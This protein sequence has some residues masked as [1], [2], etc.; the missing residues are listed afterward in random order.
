MSNL[1]IYVCTGAVRTSWIC[2]TYKIKINEL[3]SYNQIKFDS[4]EVKE[5]HKEFLEAGD[6]NPIYLASKKYKSIAEYLRA[7]TKSNE[8]ILPGLAIRLPEQSNGGVK[9]ENDF[10]FSQVNNITNSSDRSLNK[11]YLLFDEHSNGIIGQS[12]DSYFVRIENNKKGE[13][14]EHTR[15]PLPVTPQEFSDSNQARWNSVSMMGRSVDYQ[16]YTG[17]SR[18]VSF[19][20]Q[21]HEEVT[22]TTRGDYNNIHE[23]VAL[24]ESCCYP[25][26]GGDSTQYAG[27]PEVIFKIASQFYIKGILESCSATWTPPFIDGRYVNC[28]LSVSVKETTGPYSATEIADS[29]SSGLTHSAVDNKPA[30][31]RG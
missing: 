21:L 20:L 17:S 6:N 15:V 26:Y 1:Q 30:G 22:G 11:R 25:F 3:Y 12:Y 2:S 8:F 9:S 7:C 5:Y 13:V 31:N 23:I 24:V 28:N 10:V 29:P 4:K 18:S 19:T 27:P 16:I 14:T